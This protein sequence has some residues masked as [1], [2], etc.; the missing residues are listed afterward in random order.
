LSFTVNPGEYGTLG[1]KPVILTAS[2]NSL[3]TFL[4]WGARVFGEIFSLDH[5]Q[6]LEKFN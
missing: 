4:V 2:L 5:R 6:I 1:K 3:R